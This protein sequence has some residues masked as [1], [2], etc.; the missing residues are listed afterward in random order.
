MSGARLADWPLRAFAA[1][2]MLFILAPILSI[3]V[4]SFNAD[5]FPSLP[6]GGSTSSSGSVCDFMR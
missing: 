2:V 3:V 5:R 4:F 1:L 6:W